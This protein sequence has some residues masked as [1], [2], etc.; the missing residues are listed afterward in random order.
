MKNSSVIGR[1]VILT[2]ICMLTEK[3]GN[4]G[5]L[6]DNFLEERRVHILN[7]IRRLHRIQVGHP[8]QQ[9]I[10]IHQIALVYTS[11]A[12]SEEYQRWKIFR[13]KT[14]AKMRVRTL[15]KFNAKLQGL[16]VNILQFMQDLVT[17]L[18]TIGWI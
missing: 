18:A 2:F 1:S 10:L 8:F 15:D 12:I 13:P 16:V 17:L 6:R 3:S 7:L 9:F 5:L 14:P 4:I 11:L